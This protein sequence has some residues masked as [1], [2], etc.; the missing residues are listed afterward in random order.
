MEMRNQ[1]SAGRYTRQSKRTI[2]LFLFLVGVLLVMFFVS[3]GAG[4]LTLS[5]I[6]IFKTL[7]GSGTDS[8][9]LLLFQFRI[10]RLL[11]AI[12]VGIGMGVAGAVFQGITQNEL[13]DPGIIGIHSGSGLFVVVFLY[14]TSL[15][16]GSHPWW[17]PL[18][19]P[20]VA[21]IGGITAALLIYIL[22]WKSGVTPVRL[23][24]VGIGLNAGFSALLLLVQLKMSDSDFNRALV[25][26]SGSIWNASWQSVWSL[27]PWIL[28]FLPLT[29]YKARVLTVMQLGEEMALGLGTR[30]EKE[31]FLL[32]IIG[33]AM[34]ASSVAVA[35]GIAFLGLVAPHLSRRLVG[36]KFQRLIPITA[37]VGAI[38]MVVSDT[39]AR[40]LLAP[41][42]IPVGLIVSVLGA[43][44]FIYLLMTIKD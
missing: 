13:A 33:V 17:M 4:H 34:A 5:P 29:L 2:K 37:V 6:D 22:A 41:A 3:M 26:L 39:L 18:S 30:V 36:G 19:L 12:L 7:I 27:L 20:F 8:H 32:L 10:P 38:L 15:Y 24:L 9:A 25:W 31:K 16:E 35:G 40:T 42:E 11:V 44:Y 21:F 43:P 1:K 14:L 23:I 28:I